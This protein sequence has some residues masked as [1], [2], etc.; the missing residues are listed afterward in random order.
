MPTDMISI[1]SYRYTLIKA[2][3]V[4][5]YHAGIVWSG[6]IAETG[7]ISIFSC[8]L[9][10]ELTGFV[11]GCVTAL[12]WEGGSARFSSSKNFCRAPK[13]DCRSPLR[14][15]APNLEISLRCA[16]CLAQ[17]HARAERCAGH[18]HHFYAA[19]SARCGVNNAPRH[20]NARLRAGAVRAGLRRAAPLIACALHRLHVFPIAL[21]VVLLF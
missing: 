19:S 11:A 5:L 3:S 6:R 16:L 9:G 8:C 12:L 10:D 21:A 17:A 18:W 14:V 2:Y 15:H 1:G 7:D 20:A 4:E 13:I